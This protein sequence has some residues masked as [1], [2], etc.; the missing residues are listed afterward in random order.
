[1]C[2]IY[3]CPD[4]IIW[5]VYKMFFIILLTVIMT[6]TTITKIKTRIYSKYDFYKIVLYMWG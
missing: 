4:V 1:M 3:E 2:K 6:V 5:V